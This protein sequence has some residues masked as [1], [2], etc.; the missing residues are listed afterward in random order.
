MLE[1]LEKSY[2]LD[3]MSS[4]LLQNVAPIIYILFYFKFSKIVIIQSF[5][6]IW[7]LKVAFSKLQ[8]LLNLF[9]KTFI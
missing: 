6:T 8:I 5:V 2:N 4:C 3:K 9:Y 7:T 1:G